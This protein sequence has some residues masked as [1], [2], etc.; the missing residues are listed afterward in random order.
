MTRAP[1]S[2]YTVRRMKTTLALAL[3]LI[4]AACAAPALARDDAAVEARFAALHGL[5]LAS[6]HLDGKMITGWAGTARVN[7]RVRGQRVSGWIGTKYV[8]W[9]LSGFTISG[10]YDGQWV[11]LRVN[12]NRVTG[13]IAG[14]FVQLSVG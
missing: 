1:A 7:L 13:W 3:T 4:A 5:P 2:P 9:L 8:S 14:K 11:T 12:G 10:A 6:G